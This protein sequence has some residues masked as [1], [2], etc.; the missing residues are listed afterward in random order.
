MKI[1]ATPRTAALTGL[2]TVIGGLLLEQWERIYPRETYA[3]NFAGVIVALV[4]FLVPVTLF[5]VGL[6]YMQ[7]VLRNTKTR[8]LTLHTM[9]S[10]RR[11]VWTEIYRPIIVRMLC[12]FA[13]A[14]AVMLA[15]AW[16][17]RTLI[18]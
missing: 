9:W 11:A 7:L 4:F 17:R 10:N 15:S 2:W 13:S 1:V 18:G 3:Y 12:W 16:I 6:G 14:V 5:V 8:E